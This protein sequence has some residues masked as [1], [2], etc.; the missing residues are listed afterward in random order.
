MNNNKHKYN[1]ELFST[2]FQPQFITTNRPSHCNESHFLNN[3]PGRLLS[4][5][6]A[7]ARIQLTAGRQHCDTAHSHS[8]NSS[9]VRPQLTKLTPPH[10]SPFS[11]TKK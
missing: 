4:L 7:T 5:G 6:R 10:S 2:E 9:Q 3:R 11:K 1:L 8:S